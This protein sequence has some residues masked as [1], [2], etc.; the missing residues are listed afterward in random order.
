MAYATHRFVESRDTARP[1]TLAAFAD[2]LDPRDAMYW[3][4]LAASDGCPDSLRELNAMLE[5]DDCWP[6]VDRVPVGMM[7]R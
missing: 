5:A 7:G 3:P 6:F 4:A 2:S 1:E